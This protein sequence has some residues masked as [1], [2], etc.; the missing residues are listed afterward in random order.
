MVSKFREF[1]VFW[2]ILWKLALAEVFANLLIH[3][4]RKI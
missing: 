2:T 4:I 3:E 1:W